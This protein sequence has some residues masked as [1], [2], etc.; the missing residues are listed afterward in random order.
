MINYILLRKFQNL[1]KYIPVLFEQQSRAFSTP[2][3]L[4]V[5]SEFEIRLK[6]FIHNAI[7]AT[8]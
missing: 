1:H 2:F 8:L 3:K 5:V 6:C 7:L 4:L